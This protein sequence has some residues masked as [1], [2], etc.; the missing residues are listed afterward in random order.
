MSDNT[1]NLNIGTPSISPKSSWVQTERK[2][3]EAWA[4][5]A[6]KK[7]KAAALLH[8]LVANMGS[9]N[10]VV[11]SQKLL[12][13]MMGCSIDTVK[14]AVSILKEERWIQCVNINGVGTVNAYVVNDRVAWGEPRK[15]LCYSS[16]SATVM[17]EYDDQETSTL[18]NAELRKIP[19]L[20]QGELQ[21]PSGEG[22]PPPSQP[23]LKGLEPDLPYIQSESE[24][25][26]DEADFYETFGLPVLEEESEK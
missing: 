6:V 9:R 4:R 13:K 22:E 23:P 20:Y 11:V 10:A 12:A 26:M 3:H 21:L 25:V 17:A 7:P 15:N 1:R 19:T 5:L 18:E 8:V 24:L 16:F 2:A 14:R